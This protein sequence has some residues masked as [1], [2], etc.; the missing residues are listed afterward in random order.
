MCSSARAGPMHAQSIVCLCVDTCCKIHLLQPVSAAETATL[1]PLPHVAPRCFFAASFRPITPRT[2]HPTSSSAGTHPQLASHVASHG[3]ARVV[4]ARTRI[5]L[6][7]GASARPLKRASPPQMR[8]S[9]VAVA[10][11]GTRHTARIFECA[12]ALSCALVT[13]A[14]SHPRPHG[15]GMAMRDEA[16]GGTT[17]RRGRGS[18]WEGARGGVR[19]RCHRGGLAACG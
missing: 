1:T 2:P 10:F 7:G 4:D 8:G 14:H 16:M 19:E 5:N 3:S 6:H 11:V 15:G 13:R 18:R 9:A 12:G 17:R